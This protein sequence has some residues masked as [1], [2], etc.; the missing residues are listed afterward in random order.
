MPSAGSA[1]GRLAGRVALVTGAASGIGRAVAAACCAEGAAVTG[2]DRD[3]AGLEQLRREL[4]ATANP[5]PGLAVADVTS[6]GDVEGA[7]SSVLSQHGRIDVLVNAAGISTMAPVVELTE[8]DW[9]QTMA[10]NA[11]GVFLITR[12]VLPSMTGR[13][14]GSVVNIA[15]AAGKRGSRTLSHYSASKFAVIG[16]TQSAALEVAGHGVRVNSVCP[17]LIA[18]PMQER[19]IVWESQLQ[20]IPEQAVMDR[21]LAAV[22]LGR[23]GTPQDV[24]DTVVFLASDDSAYITGAAIDVGGGFAIS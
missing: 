20:G 13:G 16:F 14:R 8:D 21:Y 17:G 15:S 22:P 12:A 11:K 19:E 7:V 3:R 9:D 18:T 1:G 2:L 5:E 6:A 10:V 4:S 24:A 23:V